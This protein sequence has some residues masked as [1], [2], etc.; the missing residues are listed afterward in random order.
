MMFKILL[1]LLVFAFIPLS[2]ADAP[3]Y[4][5]HLINNNVVGVGYDGYSLLCGDEEYQNDC[6]IIYEC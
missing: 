4:Y 3:D 5:F 1:L 6:D 2:Y